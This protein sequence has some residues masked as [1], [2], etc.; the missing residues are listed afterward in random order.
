MPSSRAQ[1][2]NLEFPER[3]RS[4][5]RRDKLQNTWDR[6][7]ANRQEYDA[8]DKQAKRRYSAPIE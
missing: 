7:V 3:S 4:E 1:H 8:S 6:D 2:D 5:Q